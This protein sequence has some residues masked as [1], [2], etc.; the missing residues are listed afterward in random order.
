M[1]HI[2]TQ[3]FLPNK[4]LENLSILEAST[5]LSS[6]TIVKAKLQ[7]LLTCVAKNFSKHA[8]D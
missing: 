3:V 1:V 2:S 8:N 4:A 6:E 5:N 7:T